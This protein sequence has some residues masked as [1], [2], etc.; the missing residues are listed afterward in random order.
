MV[1]P[2]NTAAKETAYTEVQDF[3]RRFRALHGT[4]SCKELLGCDL[5]TIEGRAEFN[6]NDL[7]NKVCAPCVRDA[8]E[9]LEETV[10]T[11]AK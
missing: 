1:D 5:S 7:V 11:E 3:V 9:I 10:L 8:C 2:K 4:T 6:E